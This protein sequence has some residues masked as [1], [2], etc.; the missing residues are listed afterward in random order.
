MINHHDPRHWRFARSTQ[1][2]Q[3]IEDCGPP[4]PRSRWLWAAVLCAVVY[5]LVVHL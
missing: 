5:A 1:N 3:P 4:I 2:F